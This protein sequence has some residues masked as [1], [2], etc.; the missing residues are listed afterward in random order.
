LSATGICDATPQA[1]SLGLS[2]ARIVA[3]GAPDRSV[4][5]ARINRRDE[6]GMPPI[7]SRVV[8]TAGVELVRSWIASM[9]GCN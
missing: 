9:T 6:E 5:L 7:G 3:P 1:G 2:S 4:L 8:D